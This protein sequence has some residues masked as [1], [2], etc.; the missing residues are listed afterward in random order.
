M[1]LLSVCTLFFPLKSCKYA[2]VA[3]RPFNLNTRGR[4]TE[5]LGN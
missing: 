5:I 4:G 2:G 1:Y 3:P